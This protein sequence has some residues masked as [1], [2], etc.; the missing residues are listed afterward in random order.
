MLLPCFVANPPHVLPHHGVQLSDPED[1]A[2]KR[3]YV[4]AGQWNNKSKE[5][6]TDP[7]L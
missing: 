6:M 2:N 5:D 7:T 1:K 4:I 3:H